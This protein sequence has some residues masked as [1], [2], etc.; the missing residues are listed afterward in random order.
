MLLNSVLNGCG[1]FGARTGNAAGV[2][3]L[4]YTVTERQIED[5]EIDSLPGKINNLVGMDLLG[6]RC[7]DGLA[8]VVLG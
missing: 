7:V 1:K 6:K 4:V 3:A 2:L 5:I 8:G